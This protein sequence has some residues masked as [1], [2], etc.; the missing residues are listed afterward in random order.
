M[1]MSAAGGIFPHPPARLKQKGEHDEHG[2]KHVLLN[3]HSESADMRMLRTG[4]TLL[5]PTGVG[6]ST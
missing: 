1:P 5:R 6:F 2:G 4:Q 3:V